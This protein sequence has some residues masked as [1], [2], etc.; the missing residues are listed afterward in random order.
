M[1]KFFGCCNNLPELFNDRPVYRRISPSQRESQCMESQVP[2]D[3]DRSEAETLD[4]DISH[5][6]PACVERDGGGVAVAD[7]GA[8]GITARLVRLRRIDQRCASGSASS[9]FDIVVVYIYLFNDVGRY[10]RTLK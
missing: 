8:E 1:G 6:E 9:F 5:Q 10:P 4:R 2:L 3:M 7:D